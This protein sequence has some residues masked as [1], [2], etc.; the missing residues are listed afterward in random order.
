[1]DEIALLEIIVQ[2]S[3][4]FIGFA[5]LAPIMQTLSV[6]I[7]AKGESIVKELHLFKKLLG[8]SC[9]PINIFFLILITSFTCLWLGPNL[10]KEMELFISSIT[11]FC[12]GI[13]FLGWFNRLLRYAN[14]P[15]NSSFLILFIFNKLPVYFLLAFLLANISYLLLSQIFNYSIFSMTKFVVLNNIFFLT[16]GFLILIRNLTINLQKRIRIWWNDIDDE[17]KKDMEKLQ[18]EI[19]KAIKDKKQ[20]IKHLKDLLGTSII[21]KRQKEDIKRTLYEQKVKL[22]TF[23]R[24][25]E[26]ETQRSYNKFKDDGKNGELTIEKCLKLGNWITELTQRYLREFKGETE[27]LNSLL[28]VFEETKN[29]GVS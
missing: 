6:G 14:L 29:K 13:I 26:V 15:A 11:S 10:G 23:Q 22:N 17:F 1:M 19:D 12:F 9:L 4:T 5:V 3:A 8:L 21:N 18:E 7:T 16:I 2:V 24:E 28:K 27:K 25:I 20:L